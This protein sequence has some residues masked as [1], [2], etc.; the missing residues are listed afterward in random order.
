MNKNIF[1]ISFC[2]LM[3][4]LF[5][6]N[7]AIGHTQKVYN[8][9]TVDIQKVVANSSSV[10]RLKV[11]Y[12]R[13]LKAVANFVEKAKADI[14]DEKDINKRKKLEE[15]YNKKLNFKKAKLED[16]YN[17]SLMKIDKKITT[18]IQKEAQK[19]GFDL[20]LSKGVVLNGG[21]D[22]TEVI[23]NATK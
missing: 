9:A 7:F 8:V 4:C 23:E 15:K 1:L 3:I 17:K 13:Q 16:K 21:V 5:I 11:S 19:Q 2:G 20:V 14:Y 12:Q 10:Q 22:L 6:N 18:I